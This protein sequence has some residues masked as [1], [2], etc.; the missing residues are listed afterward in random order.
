MKGKVRFVLCPLHK[1]Y[2]HCILETTWW[3]CRYCEADIIDPGPLN[4]TFVAIDVTARSY[5]ELRVKHREV[6]EDYLNR[7]EP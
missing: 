5:E 4:H 1:R 6:M 2:S 3:R 7:I